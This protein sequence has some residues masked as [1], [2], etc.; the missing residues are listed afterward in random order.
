MDGK[1]IIEKWRLKRRMT[2]GEWRVVID[3]FWEEEKEG[4]TERVRDKRRVT[5]D[6]WNVVIGE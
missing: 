6:E 1:M 5:K 4:K 2:S 3:E